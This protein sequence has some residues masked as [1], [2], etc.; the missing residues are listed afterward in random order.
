MKTRTVLVCLAASLLSYGA[1]AQAIEND[2][3]Y[4]SAKDRAKLKALQGAEVTA[5]A[6]EVKRQSSREEEQYINPTDSYSAR[7]INPE[8]AA[9]SQAEIA[10]SDNEDYFV[11]DYKYNT[12]NNLNNWNNN[13]N[14][15][16]GNSWYRPNYYGSSINSWNSPYYGYNDPYMS[17]WGNPYWNNNSWSASF[18]Y[19]WGNSW[20]YGWGGNYNY[21]DPYYGGGW[22]PGWGRYSGYGY[23]YYPGSIIVINNGS[24]GEGRRVVYGKS[25]SRGSSMVSGGSSSY[26]GSRDRSTMVQTSNGQTSSGRVTSTQSSNRTRAEYY[27]RSWR[28]T[29][30]SENTETPTQN[31]NQNRN[32]NRWSNWSNSSNDNGSNSNSSYQR[33]NSPSYTP[34]RSSGTS[35]GG[36][37][38]SGSS[39]GSSTGGRGRTRN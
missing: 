32:T 5:S 16:Y 33:D 19:H 35:S 10:Q 7:S 17:P 14:S 9:R 2:D 3:M 26:T 12:A 15:W 18:G 6:K 13:F 29:S 37:R 28:T 31:T 36:S 24:S 11:N 1:F 4:F 25:N 8:F 21:Y 23:G 38:S 39:S 22:G 30:S 20:N 34:S 27:N